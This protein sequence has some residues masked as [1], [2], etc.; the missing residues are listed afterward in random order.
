VKTL[1]LTDE[2]LI[3]ISEALCR[4]SNVDLTDALKIEEKCE[5]FEVT[6]EWHELD[7][8]NELRKRVEDQRTL[9][10][11]VLALLNPQEAT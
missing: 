1:T 2:E 10:D 4:S 7:T 8:I 6:P 3:M 11:K 5:Q 9:R